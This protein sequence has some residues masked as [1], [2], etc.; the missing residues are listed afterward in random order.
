MH[1][2]F[3]IMA[4]SRSKICFACCRVETESPHQNRFPP[5]PEPLCSTLIANVLYK[6]KTKSYFR[7]EI[8]VAVLKCKTLHISVRHFSTR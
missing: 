3:M 2:L 7:T 6:N 5:A 1:V 8:S 4:V